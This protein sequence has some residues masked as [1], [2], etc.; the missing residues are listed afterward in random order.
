MARNSSNFD[1]QAYGPEGAGFGALCFVAGQPGQRVCADA[2]ECA[3]T[4]AAA[5]KRVFRRI[6][7]RAAQGDEVAACLAAEFT[8]PDQLLGGSDQT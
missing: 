5:R 7:E 2:D 8:S 1:C 6:S 3:R 4:M